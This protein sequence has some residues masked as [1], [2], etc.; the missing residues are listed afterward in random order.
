MTVVQSRGRSGVNGDCGT[1]TTESEMAAATAALTRT[2]GL[3]IARERRAFARRCVGLRRVGA[4]REPSHAVEQVSW[5]KRVKSGKVSPSEHRAW[6]IFGAVAERTECLRSARWRM[7][8]TQRKRGDAV[9]RRAADV[10]SER[11]ALGPARRSQRSLQ[12]PSRSRSRPAAASTGAP[13]PMSSHHF[14]CRSPNRERRAS[15][16]R[17]GAARNTMTRPGQLP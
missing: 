2:G 11:A 7:P 6:L 5:P 12:V 15:A 1:A 17:H 3:V 8:D 10:L 16:P 9:L 4:P 13:T 14:T